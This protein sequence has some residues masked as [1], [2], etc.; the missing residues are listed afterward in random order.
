MI[1]F[2]SQTID[3][4]RSYEKYEKNIDSNKPWKYNFGVP[5]VDLAIG[6][7]SGW[8]YEEYL[9][10]IRKCLEYEVTR[11]RRKDYLWVFPVGYTEIGD[12]IKMYKNQL[13]LVDSLVFTIIEFRDHLNEHSTSMS[14]VVSL[15][16]RRGFELACLW[17]SS[18]YL[19][20]HKKNDW[21]IT[22]D[23]ENCLKYIS[24][25]IERNYDRS[26]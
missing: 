6:V 19:L 9:I 17:G 25:E 5:I 3:L 18:E 11:L 15:K 24:S 7:V 2:E 13:L 1:K 10:G 22:R 23:N 26:K 4:V 16:L 8:P 21:V 20:N 14:K 12:D